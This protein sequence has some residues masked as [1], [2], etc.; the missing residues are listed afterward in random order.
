LKAILLVGLVLAV[1]VLTGFVPA[2]GWAV[3]QRTRFT[4]EECWVAD[5]DPGLWKE[6]PNGT[7]LGLHTVSQFRDETTD[8]RITGDVTV[9]GYG[10]LDLVN[11]TGPMWG[12]YEVVNDQGSWAGAWTGRLDNWAGYVHGLLVG[13]GAYDGLVV[14]ET[15]S[16]GGACSSIRGYIVEAGGAE[17]AVPMPQIPGG[18]LRG[19][20][21]GEE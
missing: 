13:S 21:R 8:P 14:N 7:W 10:I 2:T 15:Y 16:P 5:L 20:A 1:V 18:W 11:G 3:G 19:K 17:D 12:T 6:L 4:G 9:T